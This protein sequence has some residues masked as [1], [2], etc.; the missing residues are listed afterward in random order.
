MNKSPNIDPILDAPV[1]PLSSNI[2]ESVNI[3]N[4]PAPYTGIDPRL[5]LLSHS[6][7]TVLHKCPRKYQ[8][9]RLN[10]I[11]SEEELDLMKE[12]TFAYGTVVGM[13]IQSVLLG[14]DEDTVLFLM[15]LAWNVDLDARDDRR[16][17][18]FSEAVFAV[19]R[20]MNIVDN[21]YLKDYELVQYKGT[22]AIELGFW[23]HLPDE[24]SHRGFADAVLQH[25]ITKKVLV[26]ECKTTSSNADSAMY[27]NS[28]QAI[29][30]SVV[31]DH[32]FEH[33]SSYTVLYLVY[34]T[35]SKEFVEFYFDKSLLQRAIWLQELIIDM[36][37]IKLYEEYETYPMHG[38]VCFDFYKPCEYLGL[39]TL[40]TSNLTKPFSEA[41]KARIE[42][43]LNK[44][45][46]HVDFFN[47]VESQI[48]KSER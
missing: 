14:H 16:K 19:Q 12:V 35:K 13:G 39:C 44:Y 11:D 33:L 26:L 9:Y 46:F 23:I 41:D 10:S 25:K 45:H 15:F 47:L 1:T 32:L 37:T 27:K 18:S 30:Y 29:G 4:I 2:R 38:E 24:F 34:Q 48:D 31:L 36:E 3:K 5:K 21:G 40:H 17:K 20:F 43:D 6:S 42:A 22:P 28:G 7:R 8:L